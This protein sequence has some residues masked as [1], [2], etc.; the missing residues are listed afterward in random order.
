[1]R[2][3]NLI[4]TTNSLPETFVIFECDQKEVEN[5]LNTFSSRKATG[6]N[7]IPSDILHLLKKDISYPLSNIFNLSLSTGAYPDILKI[8]KAIPI[9]KKGCQLTT[10]N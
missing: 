7:S 10:S 8:A 1:M 5:I 3:T 4:Q 2:E 6:P 9:F